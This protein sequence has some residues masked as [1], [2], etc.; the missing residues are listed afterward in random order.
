MRTLSPLRRAAMTGMVISH[1]LRT[2]NQTGAPAAIARALQS[3]T[4]TVCPAAPAEEGPRSEQPM[5][6]M[7]EQS[8]YAQSSKQQSLRA[9]MRL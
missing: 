6:K 4:V 5:K 9:K 2:S 7:R 8:R 1:V 3:A